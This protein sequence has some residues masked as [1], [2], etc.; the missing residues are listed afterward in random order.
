MLFGVIDIG[1]NTV[2]LNVYSCR[3]NDAYVVFSKKESLGLGF[4]VKKGKLSNKGIKKVV[5]VL[6]HM[7]YDLDYLK[8]DDYRFFAT[9]SLRNIKNSDEVIQIIKNKVGIEIDLLSGDE[10]AELSFYGS[11]LTIKIN[12]GILIDVGGGSIE[13]VHFKDEK[14]LEEH[15]IPTGS[16]RLFNDY[17]TSMIPDEEESNLIRERI[18]SELDKFGFNNKNINFLCC[19]GGNVRAIGK[20]LVDQD[21]VKNTD[22]LIDV[23]LIKQLNKELSRNDK[24]TFNKILHVKPSRIH[25]IVPTLIVIASICSYFSCKE[26]QISRFSIREGYLFRKMSIRCSYV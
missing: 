4:Y 11:I 9:A 15:S 22:D 12:E 6:G 17:V 7:K 21:L 19:V 26:L 1:S 25:T 20:I 2:R 10:E 18:Y 24:D 3:D 8:I 23:K 14:I 16:L 5:T 13:I